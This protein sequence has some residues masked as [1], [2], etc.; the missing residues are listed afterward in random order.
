MFFLLSFPFS[1]QIKK[2]NFAKTL[3]LIGPSNEGRETSNGASFT[4]LSCSQLA[5]GRDLAEEAIII[6]SFLPAG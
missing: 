5:E 3:L 6:N 2:F 4:I 1:Q